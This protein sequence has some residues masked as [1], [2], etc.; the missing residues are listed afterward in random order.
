MQL[1]Y[2]NSTPP[3]DVFIV[4]LRERKELS[5]EVGFTWKIGIGKSDRISRGCA[6]S[7]KLEGFGFGGF[8]VARGYISI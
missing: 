3:K 8:A 4:A 7:R 6:R 1:L 5:E 2:Q